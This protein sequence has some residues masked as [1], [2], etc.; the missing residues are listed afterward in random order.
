MS[1]KDDA[2]LACDPFE[3]DFGGPG[4]RTLSDKIVTAR[5]AG[6][7][8]DCAEQIIPG[9]R[10]R[11]RTDVYGGEMMS[12]RWCNACCEAM[13]VYEERPELLD[14]RIAMGQAARRSGVMI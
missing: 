5:K 11:S 3:G 12:F 6:E 10:I 8:H 9:T 1:F 7:C 2:V 13:A 4:D 14:K